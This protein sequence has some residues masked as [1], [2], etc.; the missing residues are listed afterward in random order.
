MCLIKMNSCPQMSLTG[1]SV[2]WQ[3]DTIH[4]Q[5]ETTAGLTGSTEV[6]NEIIRPVPKARPRKTGEKSLEK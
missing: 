2:R 6:S 4:N 1:L 3:N 5:E